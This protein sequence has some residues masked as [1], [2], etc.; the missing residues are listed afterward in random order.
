[1]EKNN[2]SQSVAGLSVIGLFIIGI[3]GLTA[4][5]FAVVND[6]NYLGAGVCLAA[7]ALAFGL[8]ANAM[9]RR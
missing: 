5:L 8:L 4:A 1:M 6:Q 3:A 7:S 2:P 9:F